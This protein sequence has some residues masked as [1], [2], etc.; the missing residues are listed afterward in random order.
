MGK[1]IS[2]HTPSFSLP[3]IY[4][5]NKIFMEERT[6]TLITGGTVGI[7]YELA[8]IFAYKG[9]SLIIVARDENELN[10]TASEFNSLQRKV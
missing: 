7:G 5:L 9:H 2:P 3:G 8:K 4:L 1:P 10:L 6:Y